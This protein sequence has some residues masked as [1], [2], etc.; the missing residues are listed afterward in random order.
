VPH[1]QILE[2]SGE[3]RTESKESITAR[4]GKKV[5]LNGKD[6][7]GDEILPLLT[8]ETSDWFTRDREKNKRKTQDLIAF[9][10]K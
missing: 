10:R 9:G 4:E 3:E 2:E 6:Q 8:V 7:W 1:L 5:R